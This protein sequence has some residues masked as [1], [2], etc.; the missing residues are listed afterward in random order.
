MTKTLKKI[1]LGGT[2]ISL[3]DDIDEKVEEKISRLTVRLATLADVED[4]CRLSHELYLTSR[5]DQDLSW[6]AQKLRG[7]ISGFISGE[8]SKFCSLVSFDKK[9]NKTVGGL[10][11]TWIEPYFTSDKQ[12]IEVMMYLKPEYRKGRQGID[13]MD[14][15]EHWAKLVGCTSVSYGYLDQAP[16]RVRRLYERR[17]FTYGEVVFWRHIAQT[18]IEK[19]TEY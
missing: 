1:D 3:P 14:A 8:P 10:M 7:H 12:A 4:L 13:L 9:T 6:D 11:A 18:P 5:M 2:K 19:I 16:E 15:Y 17:G